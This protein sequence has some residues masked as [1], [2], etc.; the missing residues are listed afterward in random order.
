MT[1][2]CIVV[3]ASA[4]TLFHFVWLSLPLPLAHSLSHDLS[5]FVFP[6]L[7][8]VSTSTWTFYNFT[9]RRSNK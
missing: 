8:R 1:T 7:H 5:R 2:I 6:V 3:V 9:P 4:N